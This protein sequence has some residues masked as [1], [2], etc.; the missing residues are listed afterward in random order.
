MKRATGGD[1]THRG[2]KRKRELLASALKLFSRNGYAA[3]TID[4][5]V[6]ACGTGK[7]TFYWY[8]KS[9]EDLFKE[10]VHEKYEVF[11]QSLQEVAHNDR[12]VRERML[13]LAPKFAGLFVKYRQICRLIHVLIAEGRK[14]FE[15]DIL[16][17]TNRYYR[18]CIE[19]LADLFEEGK[20]A[21][22][23]QADLD[24]E[25]IAVL[26]VALFDGLVAQGAVLGI[27]QATADMEKTIAKIFQHGVFC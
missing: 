4:E 26:L 20:R 16:E 23:V 6:Q 7:G 2:I 3:T 1:L 15:K 10:L 18:Q 12:P 19:V 21:G 25:R 27:Q 8:W 13:E 9:K 22:V 17:M 14:S 24:A 11:L 5:I